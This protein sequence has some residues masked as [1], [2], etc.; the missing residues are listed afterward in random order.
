MN[1]LSIAS[2]HR[3]LFANPAMELS[4]GMLSA[5][6]DDLIFADDVLKLTGYKKSTLYCKVCRGQIPVLNRRKPL[7]FSK[8]AIL[9]WIKDGKPVTG[10]RPLPPARYNFDLP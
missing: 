10:K 7:V 1:N 2:L 8:S 9:Q 3:E 4:P 6:R 5:I